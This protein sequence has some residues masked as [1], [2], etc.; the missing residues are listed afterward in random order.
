VRVLL[1][2]EG[3]CR[4]LCVVR[5]MFLVACGVFGYLDLF[6]G[7]RLKDRTSFKYADLRYLNGSGTIELVVEFVVRSQSKFGEIESN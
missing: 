1:S 3:V 6:D 5:M 4:G 2:L 7:W